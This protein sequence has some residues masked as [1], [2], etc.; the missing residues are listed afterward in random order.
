M[1]VGGEAPFRRGDLYPLEQFAGTRYRLGL[2]DRR[3]VPADGFDDLLAD[4][5]DRVEGSRRLLED[6]RDAAAA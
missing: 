2:A 5:I 4:G 1:R 6:H 3:F